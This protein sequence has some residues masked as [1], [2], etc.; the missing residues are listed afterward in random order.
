MGGMQ[1]GGMPS[2]TRLCPAGRPAKVWGGSLSVGT[3]C[4]G[5]EWGWGSPVA[6]VG[7]SWVICEAHMAGDALRVPVGLHGGCGVPV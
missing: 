1:D 5:L 4:G 7:V 3:M 6:S 2:L